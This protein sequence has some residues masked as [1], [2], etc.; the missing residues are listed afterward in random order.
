MSGALAL[1]LWLAA[2]PLWGPLCQPCHGAGRGDGPAARLYERRPAD[3]TRERW[4][5]AQT[6]DAATGVIRRGLPGTGMPAFGQALDDDTLAELAAHAWALRGQAV[7]AGE[8]AEPDWWPVGGL[9]PQGEPPEGA[10]PARRSLAAAACGRCHPQQHERWAKS[11][12]G[13]AM[14]PGLTGQLVGHGPGKRAGCDPCHA[15][16]AEQAQAGPLADEGVTC[17]ACHSRGHRKGGPP[18][19]AVARLPAHSQ[20]AD[21][22]ARF[23][24][25][26]FCLPCH[27]LPPSAAVGGSPLL[28][29]WQEWAASPY[30]PAGVQCQH[31]HMPEGDHGWAGAHDPQAVRRGVTLTI[32]LNAADPVQAT[33]A[34]HNVAVGHRFPTTATPRAVL[35]VRQIGPDGPLKD[36]EESWA[37]GRTVQHEGGAWR[38]VAD[39][40]IAPGDAAVRPYR[41]PRSPDATH[42]EASLHMFPDWYYSTVYA[43]LLAGALPTAARRAFERALADA[44]GAAFLVHFERLQLP[45]R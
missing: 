2:P 6:L 13:Q 11:R 1:I 24:R 36:T 18:A 8:A 19:P 34:V 35:R 45:D 22:V 27:D 16:L 29:T 5:W 15:P 38:S 40:R 41:R 37:I 3:L 25:S 33:V 17:A 43:R 4:T 32:T 31:C 30:L 26:D 23:A 39:T 44:R 28:A 21:P 10:V 12:H 42:L 9:P 20:Q 14:G 7:G